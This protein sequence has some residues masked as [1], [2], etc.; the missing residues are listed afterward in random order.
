MVSIIKNSCAPQENICLC[1]VKS[2]FRLGAKTVLLML[3]LLGASSNSFAAPKAESIPFWDDNEP[4]SRL[5]V[6][7]SAWQAVLTK[8]VNDDHP[9]GINRFDYDAVTDADI[10]SLEGY[11]DYLLLL[12]PRQLNPKEGKAYWINFYNA[13]FTQLVIDAFKDGD[14][15]DSVEDV[16]FFRPRRGRWAKKSI[17]LL[18]QKISLEDIVN[19]ILRPQ[20]G[21]RRIH[22]VLTRASLGGPNITKTAYTGD[23]LEA[24]LVAAEKEF[25]AHP[26]AIKLDG[27]TV[28]LSGLFDD[29]DTDFASTKTELFEYLVPFVSED[30]AA[31]MQAD[32]A[33]EYDFD[34]SLNSPAQ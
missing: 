12:E 2:A 27:G 15:E 33:I 23:N 5:K 25:L 7:H 11:I 6:N 32:A 18:Q 24:L 20:F 8:Y 9:S 22:Y 1:V 31:A 17:E 13:R 19:G 26:R 4:G 10:E 14:I 29:Y 28:V 3:L 16:R 30:I 34:W 21:D